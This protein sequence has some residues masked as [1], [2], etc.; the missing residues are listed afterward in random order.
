[1]ANTKLNVIGGTHADLTGGGM[2][3]IGGASGAN[4]AL[5]SNDIMARSNGSATSLNLNAN[6]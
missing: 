4:L 2:I 1:M 3:V 6:G 5:D